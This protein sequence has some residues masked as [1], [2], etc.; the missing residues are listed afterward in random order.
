ME[1][2]RNSNINQGLNFY[3]NSNTLSIVERGITS[4]TCLTYGVRQNN[5]K[6]YYPYFDVDGSM[7]AIKT[8]SV[9]EKQFSIAGEFKNAMLFGQQLFNKGG[10]YLTIC[11]G[12]LDALAAYQMQGSKYP[13]VSIRNGAQA[14]VKDCQA[15]YE[16]IDSF[17]NVVL[18]F[19]D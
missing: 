8:R 13:C 15:Q 18:C 4:A 17:E 10:R 19:D 5:D 1:T 6:H 14:A 3:D 7:V 11:E 9:T 12:E 2:I 16:Y